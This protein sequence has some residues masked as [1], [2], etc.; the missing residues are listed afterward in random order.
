[1]A[2]N[3]GPR[4]LVR[5]DGTVVV[6]R[7]AQARGLLSRG[8]GL[9]FRRELPAGDGLWIEPC[10]SIHMFFMRF[11]LDVA[12]VDREGRVLRLYNGIKPWRATRV[13]RRARAAIELPAGTL[14]ASGVVVGDVLRLVSAPPAARA[15]DNGG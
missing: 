5:D 1:M 6:D 2:R 3:Q 14:S 8:I 9:M 15:A 7:C 10:S 11:A 4:P 12:F 13:V